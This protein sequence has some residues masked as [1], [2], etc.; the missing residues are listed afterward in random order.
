MLAKVK[1]VLDTRRSGVETFPLL[2]KE[3]LLA[4]IWVHLGST[5]TLRLSD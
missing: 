1:N 2:L 5:D 3:E 4:L